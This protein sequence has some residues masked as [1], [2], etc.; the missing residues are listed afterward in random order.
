MDTRNAEIIIVGAGIIGLA[1][2][3]IAAKSGK[4]VVVFER[5]PAAV[6]VAGEEAFSFLSMRGAA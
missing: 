2:V 6:R 1:H 3:Y 4:K 5:T